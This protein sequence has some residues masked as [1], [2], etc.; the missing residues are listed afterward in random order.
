MSLNPNESLD[1]YKARKKLKEIFQEYEFEVE[2]EVP[3]T[4]VTNNMDEDIWPPYRAD[5]LLTKQFII[6]LDSKKLHGT[7]RKIVHDRWRD[8]N[9]RN[10]IQLKT[11]RLISKDVNKQNPEQILDEVNWQLKNQKF[12]SD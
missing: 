4:T 9:V 7:H 2:E 12:D 5:M 6:E 8:E 1:T 3:L 11:V 10:Q